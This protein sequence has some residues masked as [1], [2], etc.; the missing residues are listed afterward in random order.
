MIRFIAILAPWVPIRL[1]FFTIKFLV[2]W[3]VIA[4]VMLQLLETFA[5]DHVSQLNW[6]Y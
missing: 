2:V 5:Y 1:L 6:R 3:R 4:A